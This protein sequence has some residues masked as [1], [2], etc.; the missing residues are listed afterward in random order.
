[1]PRGGQLGAKKR[2]SSGYVFGSFFKA[3]AAFPGPCFEEKGGV[4]TVKIA[5]GPKIQKKFISLEVFNLACNFQ[6]ERDLEFLSIFGSA[7]EP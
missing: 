4:Q 5:E 2:E 7:S 3:Q 6:P 1:M